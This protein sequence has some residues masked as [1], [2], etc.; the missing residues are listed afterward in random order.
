MRRSV[1]Q[2]LPPA[3]LAQAWLA[4]AAAAHGFAQRYDLPVPLPLY[5]AGAAA[6]V[7]LSFV[8]MV[9]FIRGRHAVERYPRFDLLSIAPGRGLA[10]LAPLLRLIG[11]AGLALVIAA[12]LIGDPNPFRNLA[13]TLVWV[14]WWV[15]LAYVSGLAADLWSLVNPWTTV[16]ETLGRLARRV[17]PAASPLP[18][19]R[20]PRRF[21]H[22][23]AVLLFAGFVWAELVWPS[24]DTPAS[25]A[26]AA[27]GYSLVTWAGM[28]AFGK[29]TWLR[30]GE[31]FTVAFG[32]LARFA[33]TE[34]RNAD[35]DVCAQCG[36]AFCGPAAR[37]CINCAQCFERSGTAAREL[38]LRPFAVGLLVDRPVPFSLMVFTVVMLSSVT[39]DGLLATPLWSDVAKAML[40]SETLRPLLLVFQDITGDAVS[41]VATIALLVFLALFQLVW[42]V[43][44]VLIWLFT[45]AAARAGV[46]PRQ[47]AC[48]FVFSLVPIALAYH[49]AHYL[50]YLLIVGQY[51]IPLASDPFGLGWDLFGT[52][53]YLVNIGIVNARFV[54]IASVIA[55]VAGH[56]VAVFLAHVM[57]LRVF[58]NDRAALLSQIPMLAA[59]LAYT[60]LSLW[61]LAQ[62]IVETG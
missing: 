33:P 42:L 62:P 5:L 1:C 59:M 47:V 4:P 11:V 28:L 30:H 37:D 24:S 51:M 18:H 7:A 31:A 46:T 17:R 41:A 16:Y 21:G 10:R 29:H 54:W 36:A 12:G 23:P 58:R 27:A 20:Y 56:V 49:L 8:V 14:I 38:N 35:R 19:F 57:A 55:I 60:M 15:G 45:P 43:F 32:L 6:A 3:L 25:L 40:Y 9:V 2:W 61:I 48:L 52:R 50:S 26:C 44:G 39:F 34:Y 22:W 13:P 53:H